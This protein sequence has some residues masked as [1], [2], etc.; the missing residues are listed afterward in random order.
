MFLFFFACDLFGFKNWNFYNL[1]KICHIVKSFLQDCRNLQI[2]TSTPNLVD[3]RKLT[4]ILANYLQKIYW[5]MTT[6]PP[7][8]ANQLPTKFVFFHA[9][10]L[11]ANGDENL[12]YFFFILAP[13]HFLGVPGLVDE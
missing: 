8:V 10:W 12:S 13:N 4:E 6:S 3:F 1:T 11:H 2:A 7:T 9:Y 5:K